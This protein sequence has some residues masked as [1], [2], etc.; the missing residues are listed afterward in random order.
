[1][2]VHFELWLKCELPI[3]YLVLKRLLI[4]TL[5]RFGFNS[6]TFK[7]L[8]K[9]WQSGRLFMFTYL[10]IYQINSN[11]VRPFLEPDLVF[12]E[13][14]KKC[15]PVSTPVG[16]VVWFRAAPIF[17]KVAFFGLKRNEDSDKPE[18]VCFVCARDRVASLAIFL[19]WL[20]TEHYIKL[21]SCGC[22]S[23]T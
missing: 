5:F 16:S 7:L 21:Y 2:V 4:V 19:S 3:D 6:L 20:T 8:S 12:V 13:S 11:L 17:R 14:T 18:N 22:F 23:M 10:K 15:P 1:M 9:V